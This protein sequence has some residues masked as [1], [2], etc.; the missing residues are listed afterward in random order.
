[1]DKKHKRGNILNEICSHMKRKS[2]KIN[3]KN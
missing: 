2:R 3:K 1:M